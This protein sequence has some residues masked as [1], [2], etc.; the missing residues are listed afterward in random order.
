MNYP[1]KSISG[2]TRVKYRVWVGGMLIIIVSQGPRNF[3][4]DLYYG[5]K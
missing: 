4:L 3:V 2:D 5:K 1:R